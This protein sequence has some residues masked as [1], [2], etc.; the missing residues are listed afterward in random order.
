MRYKELDLNKTKE[1]SNSETKKTETKTNRDLIISKVE[2]HT[3]KV[4]RDSMPTLIANE[5]VK[6]HTNWVKGIINPS[7][8]NQEEEAQY[9]LLEGKMPFVYNARD[10]IKAEYNNSLFKAPDILFNIDSGDVKNDEL[11]KAYY[12]QEMIKAGNIDSMVAGMEKR[13]NRGEFILFHTWEQRMKRVK[14]EE[15]KLKKDGTEDLD[16][17]GKTQIEITMEEELEWEGCVA[18]AIEPHDFFFDTTKLPDFSSTVYDNKIFDKPSCFKIVRRWMSVNDI[19]RTWDVSKEDEEKLRELVKVGTIPDTEKSRDNFTNRLG[20]RKVKGNMVEIIHYVG[21]IDIDNETLE[22]KYIITAGGTVLLQYGDETFT[23]C[24]FVWCPRIVDP[25]TLR[26]LSE[27]IPVIYLNEI[28]TRM[29]LAKQDGIKQA[30]QPSY[31]VPE[32]THLVDDKKVIEAGTLN[33]VA[34]GSAVGADGSFAQQFIQIDGYK[35]IPALTENIQYYQQLIKETTSTQSDGNASPVQGAPDKTA[36]QSMAE[37]TSGCTR[38][39]SELIDFTKFAILP[40]IKIQIQMIAEFTDKID[41]DGNTKTINVKTTQDGVCKTE[42][43]SVELLKQNL[44]VTIGSVQ[45]IIEKKAKMQGVLA[46]MQFYQQMGVQFDTSVA[47]LETSSIFE[48][49]N[50]DKWIQADPLQQIMSQMPVPQQMQFKQTFAQIIQNPQMREQV[51]QMVQQMSQP[52]PQQV[53]VPYNQEQ[54]DTAALA[55][56]SDSRMPLSAKMSAMQRQGI[57]PNQEMQTEI[58]VAKLQQKKKQQDIQAGEVIDK[59]TN[60]ELSKGI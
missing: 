46:Q 47:W 29:Q 11:L 35:N 2:T 41:D 56:W 26:G 13:L 3:V 21:D 36:L 5:Y 32:G 18:Q 31:L 7:D 49:Q 54:N 34:S 27:L 40:S 52:Q 55:I 57:V 42:Q 8:F 17:N 59:S 12:L 14:K 20:Y 48:I 43:I 16:D 22:N 58:Q 6:E 38:F 15:T 23:G 10:T 30:I 9:S 51:M 33:E 19:C 39:S 44:D 28:A 53:Q 24:R 25:T 4:I 50:A 1:V 37:I 45:A 60:S